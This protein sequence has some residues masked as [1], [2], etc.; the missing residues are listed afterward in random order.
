MAARFSILSADNLDC[1]E[2]EVEDYEFT[3][4]PERPSDSLVKA[5]EALKSLGYGFNSEKRL[6][7][8]DPASHQLTGGLSRQSYLQ[9]CF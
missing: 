7:Q 1:P 8:I 3:F 9:F 6:V 5:N 2:M 4:P